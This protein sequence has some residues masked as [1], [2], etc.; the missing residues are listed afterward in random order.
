MSCNDNPFYSDYWPAVSRVW[1]EKFEIEPVLVYV[2]SDA[3]R[4][5]TEYGTV[6][7]QE[8]LEDV[9]EHTQAQWAR[10]WYTQFEPETMWL[11][12][13]IDMMPLSTD[14]FVESIKPI[15][16][17]IEPIVHYNTTAY[18]NPET[19]V[20]YT[21]GVGSEGGVMIPTCYSLGSGKLR[22][23]TLDLVPSFKESIEKLRW[24]ENDFDHAPQGINC[25]HWYAE[26]T[27]QEEKLKEW[28]VK[29]PKRFITIKRP[30]GFCRN[31]LDRGHG[32]FPPWDKDALLKGRY[33]DF[34]MPRPWSKFGER[35]QEV[36]DV[37]LSKVEV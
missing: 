8:K 4:M 19:G 23:E 27:Y 7:Q 9:P 1:K 28:I 15:P 3:S 10:Y 31:R 13:D 25:P 17:D 33:M 36:V 18:L 11:I 6:V 22:K 37:L 12:S 35:I 32:D 5:T 24:K 26:E 2:G 21:A 16:S 30:G 20:W 29:N 34:H 14:Y